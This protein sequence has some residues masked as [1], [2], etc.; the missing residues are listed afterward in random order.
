MEEPVTPA[1]VYEAFWKPLELKKAVLPTSEGF[2]VAVSSLDL[3]GAEIEFAADQEACFRL[4][5]ALDSLSSYDWVLIDCPPS[6]GILTVNALV[7]ARWVLIPVATEYF[8]L[9]GL[10]RLIETIEKV[11]EIFNP[12]LE[13]LGI[14]A[15]LYDKRT[16]H[17]QEVLEILKEQFGEK[18]LPVV[19]KRT[20]RFA[21]APIVRRSIL[22]YAPTSEGAR[23]YRELA[24]EVIQ[25]AEAGITE[26]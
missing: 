2:H 8:A 15:T 17:A 16:L 20:I 3:V 1:T 13:L 12:K 11:R 18:F 19:I 24:K 4:R 21:E 9:R 6:L 23:A 10:A 25:R 14:L 26:S 5:H 7:A 22:S